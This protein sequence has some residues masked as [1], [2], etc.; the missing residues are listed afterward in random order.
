VKR[1]GVRSVHRVTR[2]L[3][4]RLHRT[5]Y[6]S[7]LTARLVRGVEAEVLVVFDGSE[8]AD[9]PRCTECFTKQR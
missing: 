7:R 5:A 8:G 3:G 6:C 9:L 4:S 1:L 2:V